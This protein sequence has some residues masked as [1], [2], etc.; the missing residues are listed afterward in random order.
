MHAALRDVAPQSNQSRRAAGF[1]E[2]TLVCA[3]GRDVAQPRATCMAAPVSRGS[4]IA[5][6]AVGMPS[7]LIL[8]LAAWPLNPALT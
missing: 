7:R 2:L 3:A 4:V 8:V 6:A 1:Q 5:L